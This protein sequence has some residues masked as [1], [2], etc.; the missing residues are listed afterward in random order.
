[1]VLP[2][3]TSIPVHFVGSFVLAAVIGYSAGS[4]PAA[5]LLV[6]WRSNAD[7]RR[8]GSGNVGALNSYMV[9]GSKFVGGAVLLLDLLK[10]MAAVLI[11]RWAWPDAFVLDSVAGV[12]AVV[13]HNFPVWL[14]FKGGRGLA[15][16]AGVMIALA[17]PVVGVW[18]VL[19]G[20]GYLLLRDVNPANAFASVILFALFLILPD[21]IL[22]AAGPAPNN[23]VWIRL[24]GALLMMIIL[25]KHIEP[26]KEYIGQLRDRSGSAK[27]SDGGPP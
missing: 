4:I 27:R 8:A 18:L 23:V 22:S 15:P 16:S 21:N 12:A 26:L 25:I 6:R 13:G 11:S 2:P 14:S 1:M 3:L 7:I 24:A 19:W 5:Y 10:G 9:T 17:W 20:A